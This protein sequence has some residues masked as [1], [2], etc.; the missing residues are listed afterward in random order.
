MRFLT[1]LSNILIAIWVTALLYNI[2][3]GYINKTTDK[4]LLQIIDADNFLFMAGL[5]F[6]ITQVFKRGM[7]IQSE[8]E[9]TV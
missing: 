5:V 6:I 7:E 9:L 4:E 1:R 3:G 8:N 2:F